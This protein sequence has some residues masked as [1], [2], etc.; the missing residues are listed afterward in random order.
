MF[1]LLYY[2]MYL[3]YYIILYYFTVIL[4]YY[5]LLYYPYIV[6]NPCPVYGH[7]KAGAFTCRQRTLYYI[8]Y[9]ILCY[10]SIL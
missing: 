10:P 4:L 8:I 6:Q 5:V 2:N 3:N 7:V 1:A 9:F